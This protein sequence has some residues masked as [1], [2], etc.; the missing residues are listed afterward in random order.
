MADDVN[1]VETDAF[2]PPEIPDSLGVDPLLS[3][4]VCTLLFIELSG[5]KTVDPDDAVTAEEAI[6][7]YLQRLTPKQITAIEKQ[8]LNLGDYAEQHGWSPEAVGCIRGFLT[9]AG[10]G[11]DAGD[12][13]NG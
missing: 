13:A 2:H 4:L 8:L 12:P 1:W 9:N 5:D 10:V 3:A 11:D 6:G 7:Y